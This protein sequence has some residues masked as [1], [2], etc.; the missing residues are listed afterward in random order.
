MTA[1]VRASTPADLRLIRAWLE[2]SSL[3]VDDVTPSAAIEFLVA[4]EAGQ[5]V[6]AVGLERFGS[7]GLLRSLVVDAPH[8]GA[9]L[10]AAL[11]EALER[12]AANHGMG[13]LVL[14]T[15]TAEAFFM[16]RGYAVTRRDALPDAVLRSR[17]FSALCPASATCLVR[18]L[19]ATG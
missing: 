16:A 6:G 8:R 9:G 11:V 3:P 4:T 1:T 5:P 15:T 10:G 18:P 13:R 12:H 2:A 17:E 19:R 7:T 14:L